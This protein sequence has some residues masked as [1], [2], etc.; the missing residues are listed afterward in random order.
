[1][2]CVASLTASWLAQ[3]GLT[4]ASDA[5]TKGAN[6][7]AHSNGMGAANGASAGTDT[8]AESVHLVMQSC[9][10][11]LRTACTCMQRPSA[12]DAAPL[13]ATLTAHALIALSRA[14]VTSHSKLQPEVLQVRALKQQ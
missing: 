11:Q 7:T 10:A 12:P 6:G 3:H 8:F 13:L 14:A 2:Q 1:M 4:A 5:A 9:V